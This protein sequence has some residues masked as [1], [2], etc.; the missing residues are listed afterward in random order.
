MVDNDS[1]DL[2]ADVGKNLGVTV[3]KEPI[4]Q[5]AGNLANWLFN[6][7]YTQIFANI[8]G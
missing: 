4:R 6:Y 2:T 8:C 3:I 1:T 7:G 5:I